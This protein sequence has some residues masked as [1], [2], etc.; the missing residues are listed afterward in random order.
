[1]QTTSIQW[2][3]RNELRKHPF[4][5]AATL[6]ADD[7]TEMPAGVISDIHLSYGGSGVPHVSCVHVGPL[8]S[9]SVA[10]DGSA[11]LYANVPLSEFEPYRPYPLH[12]FNGVSG[13]SGFVSFGD[14]PAMAKY[15]A[16]DEPVVWRFSSFAQSGIL[17]TLVVRVPGGQLLS[18]VDDR[19]GESVSGDV[20]LK[21]PD[22]ISFSTEKGETS[23]GVPADVATFEISDE[24][25]ERLKTDCDADG[26]A[27]VKK[28]QPIRS[29]N[30][31]RPNSDGEIAII[32]N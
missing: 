31:V 26:L 19:T 24:L 18:F 14:V 2:E 32:L 15:K 5:P 9:V 23:A 29:F 1:M 30:F 7:G 12:P 10:F 28:I 6:V 4:D 8:V 3:N 21:V 13:A 25:N 27:S 20:V 17:P 16:G 11:A 22:G